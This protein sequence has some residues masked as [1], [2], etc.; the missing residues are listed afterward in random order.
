MRGAE[1]PASAGPLF[2]EVTHPFKAMTTTR[3]QHQTRVDRTT[4]RYRYDLVGFESF[5]LKQAAPQARESAFK[6]L[7]IKPGSIPSPPLEPEVE[8]QDG[9]NLRRRAHLMMGPRKE[10]PTSIARSVLRS[11][12]GLDIIFSLS[13]TVG[14]RQIPYARGQLTITNERGTRNEINTLPRTQMVLLDGDGACYRRVPEA[15]INDHH[16]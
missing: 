3:Y 13:G 14:K 6:A 16:G 5:A 1:A 2:H 12:F 9:P 8:D 7:A 11:V 10:L 15:A 4:G